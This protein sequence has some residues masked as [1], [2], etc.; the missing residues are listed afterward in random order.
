LG[1]LAGAF[2]QVARLVAVAQFHGF[3]LSGGCSGWHGG[4]TEAPI[5]KMNVGFHGGVAARIQNFSTNDA[6]DFHD[7]V[8]LELRL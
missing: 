2:A 7:D 3:V 1:G 8:V 4:A 5:G 6:C